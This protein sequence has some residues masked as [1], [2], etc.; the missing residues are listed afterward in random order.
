MRGNTKSPCILCYCHE[1]NTTL[2]WLQLLFSTLSFITWRVKSAAIIVFVFFFTRQNAVIIANIMFYVIINCIYGHKHRNT[3]NR[4]QWLAIVRFHNR[5]KK[6][7]LLWVGSWDG[8]VYNIGYTERLSF[9]INCN[10]CKRKRGYERFN[11]I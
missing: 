10:R 5:R 3:V 11:I 1:L 6:R 8:L 4:I 7:P 9:I 2:I